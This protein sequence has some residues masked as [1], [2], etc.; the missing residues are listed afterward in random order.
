M[1]RYNTADAHRAA[2]SPAAGQGTQPPQL[3]PVPPPA[4]AGSHAGNPYAASVRVRDAIAF[5]EFADAELAQ[6]W[7]RLVAVLSDAAIVMV[8]SFIVSSIIA[9]MRQPLAPRSASL[10]IRI[11]RSDFADDRRCLHDRFA[12]TIVVDA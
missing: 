10:G 1:D 5:P 4:G 7:M 9:S 6:R 11:V 3:P 12:D 8:P 2:T